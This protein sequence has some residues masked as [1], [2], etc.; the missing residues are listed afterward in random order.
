MKSFD[1]YYDAQ[2]QNDWQLKIKATT[3]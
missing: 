3:G 2:D 1:L